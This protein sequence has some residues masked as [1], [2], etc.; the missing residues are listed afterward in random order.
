[1]EAA[2]AM[3][4]TGALQDRPQ[5]LIGCCLGEVK[6]AAG[7]LFEQSDRCAH[8]Y[9]VHCDAFALVVFLFRRDVVREAERR[10]AG[11]AERDF[12]G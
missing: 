3:I 2:P 9:G 11:D 7:Q 12:R 10:G 6:R 1:L 4:L 5:R 8:H